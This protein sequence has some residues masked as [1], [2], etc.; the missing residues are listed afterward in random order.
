MRFPGDNKARRNLLILATLCIGGV[1]YGFW[2]FVYQ[3]LRT[4]I[5]ET[6]KESRELETSISQARTEIR[7]IP[8][9][10]DEINEVTRELIN[11]SEQHMLHPRLGNYLLQARELIGVAAR[12]AGVASFQASE[13]GLIDPPR[14]PANVAPYTVRGYAVRVAAECSYAE[15]VDWLRELEESNPLLAVTQ[16]MIA[17]QPDKPEKHIIQF[18]LRWP[19]WIDPAMRERVLEMEGSTKKAATS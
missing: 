8:S 2:A 12:S 5:V 4:K 3:P 9:F 15:W 14:K 17:H 1:L 13:I 7:R 19:V 16:F 11:C 6:R 18:E 10:R